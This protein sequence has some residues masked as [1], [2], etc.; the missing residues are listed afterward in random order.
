M[1]VSLKKKRGALI[2]DIFNWQLCKTPILKS[3]GKCLHIFFKDK[4]KP[5]KNIFDFLK[6]IFF[7]FL[8]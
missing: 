1:I 6:I 2:N 8:L 3:R 5:I 4:H 7:C